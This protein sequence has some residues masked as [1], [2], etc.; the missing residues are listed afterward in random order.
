M[1]LLLLI[2]VPSA[3]QH[4]QLHVSPR[5]PYVSDSVHPTSTALCGRTG[6]R[7][8]C[9]VVTWDGLLSGGQADNNIFN[10]TRLPRESGLVH[11]ASPALSGGAGSRSAC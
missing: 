2:A 1:C 11:P 4:L 5:L 10:L 3:E 6:Y 9:K 8:A 7:S